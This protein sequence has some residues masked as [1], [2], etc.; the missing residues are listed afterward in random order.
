ML[1]FEWNK[2]EPGTWLTPHSAPWSVQEA[3]PSLPQASCWHSTISEGQQSG[4][5]WLRMAVSGVPKTTP[6]IDDSLEDS[7]DSASQQLVW[8]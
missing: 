8:L 1:A 7:W 6:R 3:P 2:Q 4:M 5:N